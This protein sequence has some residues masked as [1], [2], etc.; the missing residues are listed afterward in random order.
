MVNENEV[1][2][3]KEIADINAINA[4]FESKS[5]REAQVQASTQTDQQQQECQSC[6]STKS[7]AQS[8]RDKWAQEKKELQAKQAALLAQVE[9]LKSECNELLAL[10]NNK[11]D[12]GS[13]L[14]S[15]GE[16]EQMQRA[17]Q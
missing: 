6:A 13:A 15:T 8:T 14:G 1:Y 3:G 12:T 7:E 9:S 10:N 17:L 16:A 11:A 4:H 5:K 2:Q